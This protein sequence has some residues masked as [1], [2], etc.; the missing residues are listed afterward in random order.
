M[1]KEEENVINL[2]LRNYNSHNWQEAVKRL[3]ENLKMTEL[4][5]T[6]RNMRTNFGEFNLGIDDE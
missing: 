6:L 3:Q 1:I 4:Q 5:E 2:S